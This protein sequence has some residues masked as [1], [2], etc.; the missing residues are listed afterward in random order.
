[1]KKHLFFAA[2]LLSLAACNNEEFTP[3][4]DPNTPMEIRMSSGID[5][6]TRATHNL[7]TQLGNGEKVHV[8]VDD[9]G[10]NQELYQNNEL[11][12]DG[13]GG[14][15]GGTAM[16]FPQ[17]GN[18]V[19][20]YAVHGN[21]TDGTEW[22]ESGFWE[23]EITHT[24]A[25]DQCAN[26]GNNGYALSDLV[27]AKN[28]GETRTK[29]T[30]KLGFKHLLS[31]VEVVLVQGDGSP[32]ID[33]LEILNTKLKAQFSPDKNNSFSVTAIGEIADK[34]P[35]LID[36]GTTSKEIAEKTDNDEGKVL[37]EAIIVPQTLAEGTAFIR[38]TTVAGGVLVY[39]LPADE[40]SRKFDPEKK[41]RYTIT[42]NLTGLSVTSTIEPWG[43]GGNHSGNAEMQ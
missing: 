25:N 11:T 35:I 32:E 42:A 21:F 9:A 33:K 26:E 24:V 13:T 12:A 37:N 43:E 30:I 41:Y 18:A 4:D 10:T 38:V 34:N 1:M 16:F 39:T 28:A 5:V 14:F 31:K 20:I 23:E 36:N 6:Q 15:T 8:W 3:A 22:S 7:D 2:A 40:A 29:S 19:D 17:T 27:Y